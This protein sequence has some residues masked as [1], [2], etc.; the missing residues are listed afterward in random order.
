MI[1]AEHFA[2]TVREDLLD[3]FHRFAHAIFKHELYLPKLR[4]E[5]AR[6]NALAHAADAKGET[7]YPV[8][9]YLNNPG[10]AALAQADAC[11]LIAD[12]CVRLNDADEAIRHLIAAGFHLGRAAEWF[13]NGRAGAV[14]AKL[15][16]EDDALNEV[17]LKIK[18]EHFPTK[19]PNLNELVA[20]LKR[21]V[22]GGIIEC[23]DTTDDKGGWVYFYILNNDGSKKYNE[24]G[25]PL[26]KKAKIS[27]LQHRLDRAL[28]K[29]L[30]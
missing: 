22:G 6:I 2:Q 5:A 13:E 19:R 8:S 9:S 25:E 30:K 3:A 27:G 16:R 4:A 28:K 23:V 21:C 10:K 29:K 26:T 15:P 14:Y 7:H 20:H 11:L 17:L 12:E 24:E 18:T 1:D